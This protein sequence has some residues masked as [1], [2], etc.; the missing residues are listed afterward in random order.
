[1][2]RGIPCAIDRDRHHLAILIQLA[3]K[4]R[5][6]LSAALRSA[7]ANHRIDVGTRPRLWRDTCR[8]DANLLV[9]RSGQTS[10]HA[11]RQSLDLIDRVGGQVTGVVLNDVNLADYAQS[12][13]YSYHSYEYGTYAEDPAQQPVA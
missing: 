8:A 11:V 7:F 1:M 10:R 2:P 5:K 6:A 12:Y 4:A 3:E 9:V 13:Y